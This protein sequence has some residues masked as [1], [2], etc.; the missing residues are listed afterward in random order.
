MAGHEK[1]LQTSNS[2]P[3]GENDEGDF[4]FE[5]EDVGAGDQGVAV[6]DDSQHMSLRLVPVSNKL[7]VSEEQAKII[8]RG[9][10]SKGMREEQLAKEVGVEAKTIRDIEKGGC[11][12]D[13]VL[14]GKIGKVLGVEIPASKVSI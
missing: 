3:P 7:F 4:V 8:K 1:P 10:L 6:F 14:I 11:V 2:K 12:L 13:P 5:M 9:R